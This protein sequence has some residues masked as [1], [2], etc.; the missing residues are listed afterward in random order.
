M[1]TKRK[2]KLG[3]LARQVHARVDRFSEVS[4]ASEEAGALFE[5]MPEA[6]EAL[7]RVREGNYGQ[8]A[9]CER[10]IP[11]ARL[12][13]KPEAIRC[14]ACQSQYERQEQSSRIRVA[15]G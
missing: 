10:P 7:E 9:D 14:V 6:V 12:Q 1:S 3:L 4:G 11:L 5:M 2:A 8:C 13:I 15:F